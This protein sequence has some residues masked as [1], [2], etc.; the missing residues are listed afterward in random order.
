MVPFFNIQLNRKATMRYII[1][2]VCLAVI[3]IIC[4]LKLNAEPKTFFEVNKSVDRETLLKKGTSFIHNNVPDSAIAYFIMAAQGHNSMSLSD[5]DRAICAKAL[6]NAGYVQLFYFN[7]YP[8]AYSAI[9]SSNDIASSLNLTHLQCINDINLGS[10]YSLNKDF[11]EAAQLYRRAFNTALQNKYSDQLIVAFLDLAD[12]YFNEKDELQGMQSEMKVFPV[13]SL[14]STNPV[15]PYVR[16]LFRGLKTV[17]HASPEAITWF[18]RAKDSLIHVNKVE[19]YRY[20]ADFM[21]SRVLQHDGK[22]SMAAVQLKYLLQDSAIGH[23]PDIEAMVYQRIA[24]CYDEAH[25][26][27]SAQHYKLRYLELNDSIS[28][29]R[30]MMEVKDLKATHER[31]V[32][33]SE[34]NRMIDA[35]MF[36]RRLLIIIGITLAIVLT[37]LMAIVIKN[38]QLHSSNVELYMRNRELLDLYDNRT[39]VQPVTPENGKDGGK[40]MPGSD[41]M[42]AL[43]QKILEVMESE[44]IFSSSFNSS[45]LAALCETNT[46]YL[47]AA[48]A[49]MKEGSFP[50]L[51]AEVRVREAMRRLDGSDTNYANLT[52]EAVGE[53]VGFKSRSTFSSAFKRI[54]GLTPNEYRRIS[55]EKQSNK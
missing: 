19:R 28:A 52:I 46:R 34:I 20:N 9:I 41:F 50:A 5:N 18:N 51:L 40:L 15:T 47:S 43:R 23:N 49:E 7:D 38:R 30:K 31:Q 27:D 4:V 32:F 14:P 33:A 42:V 10:I 55:I 17:T 6:S 45:R 22:P 26:L 3:L 29:T 25:I 16:N 11:D 8:E 37:L 35:Q 39:T 44:E 24:Q 48:L 12:I 54:T 13:D 53:S 21:I 36:Q 2:V 1:L